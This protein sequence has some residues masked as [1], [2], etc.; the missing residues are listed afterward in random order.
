MIVLVDDPAIDA[1]QTLALVETDP[2]STVRRTDLIHAGAI[3]VSSDPLAT[4]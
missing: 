2:A 4:V 3:H 1:L